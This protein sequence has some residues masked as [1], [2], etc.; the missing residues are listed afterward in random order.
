MQYQTGDDIRVGDRVRHA[1][2]L[3][4]VVAVISRNEYAP[5]FSR[6]DW[7]QYQ[8]GFVVQQDDGQLFM[9]DQADEDLELV[10]RG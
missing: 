5:G 6:E 2:Q 10:A 3:A 1:G 4:R 8:Q 9:Y 7:A